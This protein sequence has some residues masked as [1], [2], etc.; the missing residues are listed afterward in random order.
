[1]NIKLIVAIGLLFFASQTR[2][3]SLTPPDPGTQI[4]Y[5]IN[6]S[7]FAQL[8]SLAPTDFLVLQD[9]SFAGS[10]WL[11][12]D[13]STGSWFLVGYGSG[14]NNSVHPTQT[15][16]FPWNNPFTLGNTSVDPSVNFA[17]FLM[18][19]QSDPTDFSMATASLSDPPAPMP[20][21]PAI[22]LALMG[23]VMLIVLGKTKNRLAN[24]A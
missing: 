18:I 1:M 13:G 20:E 6:S 23:L 3:D 19:V 5:T 7:D 12:P 15:E 10:D 22:L 24:R 8:Y 4:T 16:F 9:L 17:N 21:P 14:F 2:A 11:I